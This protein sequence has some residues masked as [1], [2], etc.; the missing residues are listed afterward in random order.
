MDKNA[1]LIML[2]LQI[3]F[4]LL[5]VAAS[6]YDLLDL[7]RFTL[8]Q[9]FTRV[10]SYEEPEIESALVHSLLLT[11]F[12]VSF[13]TVFR[14]ASSP[15]IT[16]IMLASAVFM[17]MDLRVGLVLVDSI[18]PYQ[19]LVL[20]KGV[21]L[22]RLYGISLLF[23]SGL[24]H[25]GIAYQK[26]YMF[27]LIALCAVGG[28]VYLVPVDTIGKVTFTSVISDSPLLILSR[29]IEIL[30]VLNYVA[31]GVRNRNATF[32]LIALG[33]ALFIF[34]NEILMTASNISLLGAGAASMIIGTVVMMR[35][36]YLL[37]LWS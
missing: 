32:F 1:K 33:I 17:L 2:I 15:E 4:M 10:L 24:F 14:R 35:K 29:F 23:C 7:E 13:Y 6:A 30:A 9:A 19:R 27:M 22:L 36:F 34:G 16:Y 12:T 31:A 25:N 11:I 5:V 26:K 21:Y 37:H 20:K 18:T 8:D 3:L 28:I